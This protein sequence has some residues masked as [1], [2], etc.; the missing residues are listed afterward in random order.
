MVTATAKEKNKKNQKN[1]K[2]KKKTKKKQKKNKKT[3]GSVIY[4]TVLQYEYR[5]ATHESRHAVS[6]TPVKVKGTFT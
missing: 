5:Q 3:N 4:R 6:V 1:K 2:N